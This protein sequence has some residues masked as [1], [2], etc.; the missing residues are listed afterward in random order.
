MTILAYRDP[1]QFKEAAE[2]LLMKNEAQNCLALGIIDTLITTRGRYPMFY[3]LTVSDGSRITG[4]A[5]MTPPHPLG[6]SPMPPVA[7]KQ[8]VEHMSSLPDKV[9]GVIGPKPAVEQFKDLWLARQGIRV[10][11]MMQQRIYQ[12]ERVTPP[13]PVAG[14]MRLAREGDRRLLEQ[15]NL[16]F[17]IDSGLGNDRQSAIAFADHD[18]TTESR[19]FWELDGQP[20]SM[21]GFGGQTPSGIRVSR[22]YTPREQRG[23]GHASAL[24]AAMSQKLLDQGRKFCFLYTDLANPT[25]NS[26]YQRIGYRPVCDSAHYTFE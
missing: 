22:V 20:V 23:R 26:I 12:L 13:P 9:S 8:L 1:R 3:L 21:A 5:W 7:V 14:T 11:S 25:S 16:G 6:L 4:V 15:W 19:Y 18:I 17:S 24:V 10:R 2:P